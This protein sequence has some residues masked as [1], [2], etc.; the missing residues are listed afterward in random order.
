VSLYASRLDKLSLP[1]IIARKGKGDRK[2][3]A[4]FS[5]GTSGFVEVESFIKYFLPLSNTVLIPRVI[6]DIGAS[7]SKDFGVNSVEVGVSFDLPL[8]RMSQID[9][10]EG[11]SMYQVGYQ[12]NFYRKKI[13]SYMW[14]E[15]PVIANE[16]IPLKAKLTV[17]LGYFDVIPYFEDV[18][19]AIEKQIIPLEAALTPNEKQTLRQKLL[20]SKN[21]Y[22]ILSDLLDI[23]ST[24]S[25]VISCDIELFYN[26]CVLKTDVRHNVR[27]K[28]R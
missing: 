14:V 11:I 26:S 3:I 6:E 21:V 24:D 4:N 2:V 15:M 5:V 22:T 7:I 1:I 9:F 17:V 27:W 28:G 20:E 13:K 12:S 23:Y 18:I 19:F 8:E 25:H 10:V 16:I